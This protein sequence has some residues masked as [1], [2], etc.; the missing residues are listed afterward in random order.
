[1]LKNLKYLFTLVFISLSTTVTGME[2]TGYLSITVR[3]GMSIYIDTTLVAEHSVSNIEVPVGFH[4]I[5]VYDPQTFD[6]S[7]RGIIKNIEISNGEKISLDFT[8]A[9]KIKILS[10]PFGSRVFDGD[11]LLGNT[12]LTYNLDFVERKSL[13]VEK[14]GYEN[15]SIN[16]FKG[17]DEYKISL[18]PIEE[19]RHLKVARLPDNYNHL[20]WYRE[21][22][23]VT[24]LL[25]SWASFYFKRHAD[26]AY[27]KYK[28]ASDSHQIE[29]LYNK[30]KKYDTIAD[31]A[32]AISVTTLGT[33]F[34]LLLTE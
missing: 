15:K 20:R 3:D 29:T 7:N 8:E 18:N 23:I 16:L 22:L 14:D 12:P 28:R 27:D 32:I 21:G 1:M 5:H 17:H 25:S 6:W 4:R 31:I 33:Y 34:Y 26:D 9:Q 13:R 30:T 19:D 2:R 24:S 11:D 10:L